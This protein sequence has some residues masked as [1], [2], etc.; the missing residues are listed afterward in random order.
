VSISRKTNR[1][2]AKKTQR[3]LVEDE[4]IASQS[5]CVTHTSDHKSRKLLPLKGIKGQNSQLTIDG[6]GGVNSIV[7]G[8]GGSCG[9]NKDAGTRRFFVVSTY[10]C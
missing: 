5:R 10:E 8:R 4:V 2:H 3:P 9:T 6:S 7:A 1:D